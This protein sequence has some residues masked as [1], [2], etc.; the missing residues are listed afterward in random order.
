M[1]AY[2]NPVDHCAPC[3]LALLDVSGTVTY[4]NNFLVQLL[5]YE[6]EV[7]HEYP[8]N[9][10][11][12]VASRQAFENALSELSGSGKV[13]EL[14][15]DLLTHERR[16]IPV[17]LNA[18]YES[19]GSD[20]S[21]I[22]RIAVL[23][24]KER[25]RYELE[26]KRTREALLAANTELETLNAQLKAEARSA[27]ARSIRAERRL[28][29]ERE[30]AE[31]REEFIAVLGHDL[32]NPLASISSG[33]R[34]L[35]KRMDSD[36]SNAEPIAVMQHSVKRMA[37]LIDNVLDF[38]RGRLGGGITLSIVNCDIEVVIQQIGMEMIQAFPDRQIAVDLRIDERVWCD[39]M[40]IGQLV[41]NLM[42]NALAHGDEDKPVKLFARSIA[43]EDTFEIAVSN[44]GKPISPKIARRLFLP[45]YRGK[46][47]KGKNGLGLGL[48]IAAEI[49]KAHQ[50]SLNLVSNE[51]QTCFVFRMPLSQYEN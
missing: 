51:D 6:R 27:T 30:T 28:H 47:R 35:E 7:L 18:R 42:S 3:G 45:F 43:E 23:P 1:F 26:I 32:R 19:T 36:R 48:H 24:T 13:D 4:L 12:T 17:L 29:R 14:P 15:L 10:L 31:L 40:R 49:A 38:A 34:I 44:G 16:K 11:L 22:I 39:Q 46:A 41:S 5:G 9:R 37:R 20:Y 33:L 21:A 2:V 25:S 8:F 50:G